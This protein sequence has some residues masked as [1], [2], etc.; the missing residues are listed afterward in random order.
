LLG[1]QHG[2]SAF[3]QVHGEPTL[4]SWRL[5]LLNRFEEGSWKRSVVLLVA[6][7]PFRAPD[8]YKTRREEL[9]AFHPNHRRLCIA[10]HNTL[11]AMQRDGSIVKLAKHFAAAIDGVPPIAVAER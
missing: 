9:L 10:T 11:M 3:R 8:I 4:E 5:G 1:A 7:S 6:H 2:T